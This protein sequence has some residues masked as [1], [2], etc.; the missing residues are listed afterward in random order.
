M[1]F[2][3]ANDEQRRGFFGHL[4]GEENHS[5][6]ENYP[7]DLSKL[8]SKQHKEIVS[9]LA[10]LPTKELRRRQYLIHKQQQ[11]SYSERVHEGANLRGA[12]NLEVMRR[13][14]AAAVDKREFPEYHTNSNTV[15]GNARFVLGDSA[16]GKVLVL[17]GGSGSGNF[18]HSGR[19]G[20]VGGSS[21]GGAKPVGVRSHFDS[22]LHPMP[23]G[24][25]VKARKVLHTGGTTDIQG[26]YTPIKQFAAGQDELEVMD[27]RGGEYSFGPAQV[28]VKHPVSG[29]TLWVSRADLRG[30]TTGKGHKLPKVTGAEEPYNREPVSNQSFWDMFNS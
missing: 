7:Q 3:F 2:E 12:N 8:T 4:E 17:N 21:G 14:L 16:T 9:K 19:P 29:E 24:S 22:M 28:L 15:I 13:H 27:H 11:K 30:K 20:A 18:G 23:V 1:P 26:N 10:K 5:E 25:R 6:Y